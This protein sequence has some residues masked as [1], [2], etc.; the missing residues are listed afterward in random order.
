M[1]KKLCEKS[2]VV[3]DVKQ[4]FFRNFLKFSANPQKFP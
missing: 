2:L 4:S 1:E 3:G